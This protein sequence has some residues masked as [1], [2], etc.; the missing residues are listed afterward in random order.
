MSKAK[1]KGKLT[2]K[3]SPKKKVVVSTTKKSVATEKPARK[4]LSPTRSRKTSSTS[5]VAKEPL[6]FGKQNYI[7]MGIGLGLISLGLI[8]MSGGSMPSPDV[9]DENI[10]YGFR[11]TV[12]APLLMLA[13]LVVEVIAIFKK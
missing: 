11:R 10:I 2:K 7:W 9:W 6:I 12:L 5:T 8:L 1:S 3:I 4:K 13:G